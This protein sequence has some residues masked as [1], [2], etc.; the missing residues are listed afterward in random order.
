MQEMNLIFSISFHL[1][2]LCLV[3]AAEMLY[4]CSRTL[5]KAGLKGKVTELVRKQ[6]WFLL[7]TSFITCIEKLNNV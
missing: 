2:L 6:K 3:T 4:L 5:T 1:V 7:L